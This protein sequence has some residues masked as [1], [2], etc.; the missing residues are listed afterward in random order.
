ML[1]ECVAAKS[2]E[3]NNNKNYFKFLKLLYKEQNKWLA[4]QDIRQAL[5]KLSALAGLNEEE[6]GK[7]LENKEI[8]D[9]VLAD[10]KQG[11]ADGVNATP[12]V[13]INGKK[14][15]DTSYKSVKNRIEALA[16]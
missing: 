3:N 6:S 2:P 9:S 15:D 10:R 16:K 5:F 1:A 4:A 8:Y 7:C 13:F 11:E 12:S 14:L